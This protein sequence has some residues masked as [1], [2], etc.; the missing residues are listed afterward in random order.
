MTSAAVLIEVFKL[1]PMTE[2]CS[3]AHSSRAQSR[4]MLAPSDFEADNE[5]A[6]MLR[7]VRFASCIDHAGRDSLSVDITNSA[8][9][10]VTV[11]IS[12]PGEFSIRNVIMLPM[13]VMAKI[14]G[15]SVSTT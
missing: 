5:I 15:T 12:D 8:S 2:A 1:A 11:F 6:S 13:M 4:I 7:S 10:C 14:P 3:V 9:D